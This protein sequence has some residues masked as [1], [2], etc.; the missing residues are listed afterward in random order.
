MINGHLATVE[1][2]LD[3]GASVRSVGIHGL[4]NMSF[5]P[6]ILKAVLH[7]CDIDNIREIG[8]RLVLDVMYQRNINSVVYLSALLDCGVDVNGVDPYNL[9]NTRPTWLHMA[10]RD[11]WSGG[12]ACLL[13]HGADPHLVDAAGRTPLQL[14]PAGYP[15]VVK[16]LLL[17]GAA[18][19]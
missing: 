15:N 13:Q 16:L 4:E 8:P 5:P 10:A 12:V 11:G 6:E 9:D 19:C 7:R 1:A 17:A 14:V 2:L 18:F 3:G